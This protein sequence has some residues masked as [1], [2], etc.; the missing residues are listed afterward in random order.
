MDRETELANIIL[1]MSAKASAQPI[2][3]RTKELL[4]MADSRELAH[5]QQRVLE[6]GMDLDE[7]FV[8]WQ[9]NR[10]ILPDVVGTMRRELPDNHLLQR[11]L[12]EHDMILCFVADLEEANS[13]VQQLESA[14]SYTSEIRRLEHIVR[15]L[16]KAGQHPEREDHVIF[17]ELTRRG[18]PGPS[19]VISFQHQQLGVNIEELQQLVWTVDQVALDAFKKRV[20][21]LVEYIVPM[22]RRHIFIENNLILPLALEVIEDPTCWAHMKEVCDNIGYCGYDAC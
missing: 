6:A 2:G 16:S 19:E 7:L 4:A 13:H 20:Q 1:S 14:S 10:R 8:T 21:E 18:F 9:E 12:A 15:H 11:I 3:K 17:P 5:A 22:M